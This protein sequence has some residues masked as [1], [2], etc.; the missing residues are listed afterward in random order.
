MSA[1]LGFMELLE[2][3]EFK[4]KKSLWNMVLKKDPFA[5]IKKNTACFL[6]ARIYSTTLFG[7]RFEG[8][9]SL[10]YD[11]LD[12]A[13]F[14]KSEMYNRASVSV[15]VIEYLQKKLNPLLADY[16]W[17]YGNYASPAMKFYQAVRDSKGDIATV[18][19]LEFPGDITKKAEALSEIDLTRGCRVN[20]L[21]LQF[22]SKED[23][24]SKETYMRPE[25]IE[26]V[27][28]NFEEAKLEEL[29]NAYLAQKTWLSIQTQ[30]FRNNDG[31]TVTAELIN[32][33]LKITWRDPKHSL[34]G[35][36][37]IYR[38]EGGFKKD[39]ESG[40]LIAD[41]KYYNGEAWDYNLDLGKSYYYTVI[42]GW[43]SQERVEGTIKDVYHTDD[44]CRFSISASQKP[45]KT[46][47]Q[48]YREEQEFEAAKAK[49]DLKQKMEVEI[50][51]LNY[52]MEKRNRLTKVRDQF[53]K[54]FLDG[55][56]LA[57][58]SKDEKN[59]YDELLKVIDFQIRRIT[60]IK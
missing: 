19:P 13:A 51:A 27:W 3:K 46:P 49:E 22:L 1:S 55:R 18:K 26:L 4:I 21:T 40:L 60:M 16:F 45:E 50:A 8:V 48:I 56:S 33:N 35:R 30:S 28:D 24:K 59:M 32:N 6:K 7:H 34:Q 52:D 47:L 39:F 58:L 29:L 14:I 42:D 23:W 57:D 41:S 36:T 20:F 37:K 15:M 44:L 10:Q 38:T 53:A 54:G 31:K 2:C 12:Q 17:L 5:D 11:I 43:I 25:E 9:I